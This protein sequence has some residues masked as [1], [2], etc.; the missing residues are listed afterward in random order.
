MICPLNPLNG[1]LGAAN[2][3]INNIQITHCPNSFPFEGKG[4]GGVK[5]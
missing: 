1:G 5:K 2:N 4:W 3:H